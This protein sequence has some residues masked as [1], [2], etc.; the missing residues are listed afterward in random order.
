MFN[1]LW[2]CPQ[3]HR[4]PFLVLVGFDPLWED[5]SSNYTYVLPVSGTPFRHYGGFSD[6][7][8]SYRG[9]RNG[10]RGYVSLLFRIDHEGER[11]QARFACSNTIANT[12]LP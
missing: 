1:W 6:R 12:A 3:G 9:D 7:Y 8:Y 4:Y 5:L 2:S 10:A 11:A